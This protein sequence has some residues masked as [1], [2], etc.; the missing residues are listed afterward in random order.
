[1]SVF[2]VDPLITA[3]RGT[4]LYDH[5]S[6]R[7]GSMQI[8]N[9]QCEGVDRFPT[10][11]VD[12][13]HVTSPG[14]RPVSRKPGKPV[15]IRIRVG[16]KRVALLPRRKRG[17]PIAARA[18]CGRRIPPLETEEP[19]VHHPIMPAG[20]SLNRVTNK[21]NRVGAWHLSQDLLIVPNTH[22][23]P[24]SYRPTGRPAQ[25]GNSSSRHLY[26]YL[27]GSEAVLQGTAAHASQC[28]GKL[29]DSPRKRDK[30]WA[31]PLEPITSVT[32]TET[33]V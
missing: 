30:S 6:S 7:V 14:H 16:G 28:S 21:T 15:D 20:A 2:A 8:F 18:D 12:L 26:P 5:V 23:V 9:V 31:H 29:G 22:T 11:L 3:C 1:M 32:G 10:S 19:R 4:S 24:R 17:P 25:S 13:E 33:A 27:V